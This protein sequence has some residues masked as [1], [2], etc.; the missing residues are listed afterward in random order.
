MYLDYRQYYIQPKNLYM[1][2][3][4]LSAM[5]LLVLLPISAQT[6][7]T[8]IC[9]NPANDAFANVLIELPKVRDMWSGSKI[10]VTY[11]G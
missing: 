1:K 3:F 4:L 6:T 11:Q 9:E 5:S 7:T 8:T 10:I 2:Q